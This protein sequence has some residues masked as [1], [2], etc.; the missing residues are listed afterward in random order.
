M[1]AWK[2]LGVLAALGAAVV[3]LLLLVVFALLYG[4]A[5]AVGGV[6]RCR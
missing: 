3:Y 1:S 6:F 5:L 2:A 4:L